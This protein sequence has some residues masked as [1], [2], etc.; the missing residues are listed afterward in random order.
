MGNFLKYLQ[1]VPIVIGLI[2]FIKEAQREYEGTGTN[3][4]KLQYVA[5]KFEALVAMM[6][7]AGVIPE[8]LA[9][10]L[11][12]GAEVIIST[13]VQLMNAAEG[14]VPIDPVTT[15]APPSA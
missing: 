15:V 13:I 12:T 4:Q 8:K 5:G 2:N 7:T 14:G 6:Q 9:V 1:Y 11:K 10:T 3:A